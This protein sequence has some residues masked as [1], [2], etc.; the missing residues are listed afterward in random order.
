MASNYEKMR[1][2]A[3]KI[4]LEELFDHLR[5]LTGLPDL[6]FDTKIKENR[7]GE[8]IITFSSQ[9][10]AEKVGFLKLIFS[11]IWIS[12]FNSSIIWDEDKEVFRY[13]GTADFHYLHPH[14]GS[15]GCK[16]CTFW[17]DDRSG[18]TFED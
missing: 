14:G 12:Q 11:E 16:F 4:P 3:E 8:P 6:R 10:L 5:K 17:Y 1:D 18:W 15:N 13:W 7:Y 9:D 2:W